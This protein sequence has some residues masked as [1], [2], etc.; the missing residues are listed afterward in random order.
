MIPAE[1]AHLITRHQQEAPIDVSAIAEELGVKIYSK[2]LAEG[3]SGVIVRDVQYGTA[4]GFAI[5]VARDEPS[6]R[7]RFTAAHELG[8]FVL[9]KGQIG[10]RI[11]DNYLLRSNR[12]SNAQEV[13][14]NKFAAELLMPFRLI[15]SEMKSAP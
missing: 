14:A 7:Q 15:E 9:H 10:D 11:E 8:H 5:F 1:I 4:S 3:V 2:A 6:V 12:L 13:E